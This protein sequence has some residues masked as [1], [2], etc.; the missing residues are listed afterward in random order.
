M[1]IRQ[2]RANKGEKVLGIYSKQ[3]HK[4]DHTDAPAVKE[5]ADRRV[6]VEAA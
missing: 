6:L 1:V 5:V 3:Q 2:S 4:E